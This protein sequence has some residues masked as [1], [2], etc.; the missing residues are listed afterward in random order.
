[1]QSVSIGSEIPE[2]IAAG[3]TLRACLLD[4]LDDRYASLALECRWSCMYI[5][6][7]VTLLRDCFAILQFSASGMRRETQ[8]LNQAGVKMN[9]PVALSP[10]K[11]VCYP[12]ERDFFGF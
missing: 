2:D 10:W 4:R 11:R 7:L 5:W 9:M 8:N 12:F 3:S 1:M 6:L